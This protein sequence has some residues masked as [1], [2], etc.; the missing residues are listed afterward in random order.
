MGECFNK[1]YKLVFH[2]LPPVIRQGVF[3]ETYGMR[4]IVKASII[5]GCN[6]GAVV[7]LVV[8]LM[9]DLVSGN[10]LG[11]GWYEAVYHDVG[12]VFGPQW[13]EKKWV[14]YS[15]IV[16]VVAFI[17]LLGALMG[18]MLGAIVGKMLSKMIE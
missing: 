7:G 15:G 18:A 11:G 9:L 4:K 5:T 3:Q 2:V 14:I 16:T 17:G 8:A 12:R 1:T 13:A 10:A 6:V